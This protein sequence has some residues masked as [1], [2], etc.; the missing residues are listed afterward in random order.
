MMIDCVSW[1]TDPVT[2]AGLEDDEL[3]ALPTNP[4]GEIDLSELSASDE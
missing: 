2:R 4:A 3:A 1:W